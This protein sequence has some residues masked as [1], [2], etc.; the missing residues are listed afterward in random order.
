MFKTTNT[1]QSYTGFSLQD[2]PDFPWEE[3]QEQLT[4]YGEQYRWFT[5]DAL[6]D[7]P[8]TRAGQQAD[9]YPVRI[10]P[11]PS[12]VLKH[13]SALIGE[14]EDDGRPP[15]TTRLLYPSVEDEENEGEN[16]RLKKVAQVGED[17]LNLVWWE[18]KARS[19]FIENAIRSQIFG[20][21]FFKASLVPWE[22]NRQIPICIE[23]PSPE[24]V[25]AFPKAGS[26]YELA[27]AWIV[28]KITAREAQRWG[29]KNREEEDIWYTEQ[30]LPDTYEI[31][32]NG[33]PAS[34]NG[35]K[36]GGTNPFGIVP[37][38]YIPHL[39]INEFLGENAYDALKAYVTELN[40]RFGDYGDA[41]NDDSHPIVATRDISGSIQVKRVT[42]WLEVI[43]LG[44]TTSITGTEK[45]PD[46]FEVRTSR[47]SV[48]M[49]NL[50]ETIWKQ[51]E[52]DALTPPVAY[53]EDE[54]SQRSGM[55]LAIRFWPL[56]S[57]ATTERFFWT[58][59]LDSFQSILLRIMRVKNIAGI[60]DEHLKLR[61]KHMWAPMLPRDREMDVQEWASRSQNNLS[62]IEHLISIAG[63]VE[64][65][66]EE[67]ARILK[68]ITDLE[69][70]KAKVASKYAIEQQELQIEATAE[71]AD[72]ARESAEEQA[73]SDREFT[74]EQ[75]DKN[76]ANTEKIAKQR[77]RPVSGGVK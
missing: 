17:A 15:V 43:D 36:L 39:R 68:W 63:D 50:I 34:I 2:L 9:L 10:N 76:N 32:I 54:G 62:S 4:K 49:L 72:K 5:G 60:T 23:A 1:L 42:G 51:Y 33:E 29:Y 30:W 3:Y 20:G 18:N 35:L 41:V 27:E 25:I 11:I 6:N 56:V 38:V 37:I 59:G 7:Q 74:A 14:I 8:Q 53:G 40:L 47:A 77:P 70:A 16:T 61:M 19:L 13:A 46:M 26:N 21:C 28:R 44:Q 58:S 64:D 12:T 57:H 67:R 45:P 75:T 69:D 52:R 71:E 66:P 55:T 65:I 31:K 73:E 24:S 22:K 48:S